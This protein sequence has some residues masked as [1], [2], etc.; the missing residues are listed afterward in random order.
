VKHGTPERRLRAGGDGLR[1]PTV[2]AVGQ[3][4]GR[5]RSAG[6]SGGARGWDL[7]LSWLR[8]VAGRQVPSRSR[9]VVGPRYGGWR[10]PALICPMVAVDS[11]SSSTMGQDSF[12]CGEG[13]QFLIATVPL[14]FVGLRVGPGRNPCFVLMTT[15]PAGVVSFLKA[16]LWPPPLPPFL[17]HRGKPYVQLVG[18]CGGGA[19]APFPHWVRCLICLWSLRAAVGVGFGSRARPGNRGRNVRHIQVLPWQRLLQG[20]SEPAV[21]LPILLLGTWVGV[22]C[23]EL[24]GIKVVLWKLWFWS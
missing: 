19:M 9:Q 12:P 8:P 17:Q 20:R 1:A 16:S 24:L 22:H 18:P 11:Q 21:H 2:W 10:P 4:A 5:A 23:S 13:L 6:K 3:Q 14:D 15:M 7:G